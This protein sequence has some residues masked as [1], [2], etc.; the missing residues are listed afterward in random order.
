MKSNRDNLLPAIVERPIQYVAQTLPSIAYSGPGEIHGEPIVPLSHYLWILRLH[1]WKI[2]IFVAACVLSTVIIS[3]RLVRLYE[4]TAT[5]DIDR[6]TPPGIIGE[7]AA[8]SAVNDADQFLATQVKLI[9]SDSVLRPVALRYKLL[10]REDALS[11]ADRSK[12]SAREDAPII[13]KNLKV[14]R[15]PNTYL[16]LVNYRSADPRLAADVANAIT[17][18]YIMHTFDLRFRASSSLSTFMEKQ[19]EELHAKME[20]STGALVVFEKELN[21]IN[22]EEKTSILSSRLLQLNT[23]YTNAQADRVRKEAESLSVDDNSMEAALASVQGDSLRKLLEHLNEAQEKFAQVGGQY[24][25]NHPEYRKAAAQVAEV[26]RLLEKTRQNIADRVNVGHREAVSREGMLRAAVAETKA[27][28][29]KLNARSFEYQQLKREAE[30]DK[31]LYEELVRRIKEAGINASFQ[32][33]SIRLADAARPP[34]K[35]VFPDIPLNAILA[36]L[37]SSL[38]AVGAAVLHDLLDTTVRSAED[39]SRALNLAMLGTLPAVKNWSKRLSA[40]ITKGNTLGSA[41]LAADPLEDHALAGFTESVRTLRNNILLADFDRR[42]RTIL[43]TS[44]S[45]AEGKSTIAAHLAIAHA[46]QGKKTLL[47]DGDLRRPSVH[48]KFGFNPSAGLSSVLLEEVKWPQVL[49]KPEG[50]PA[51][52]ILPAGPSSHRASEM[53]GAGMTDL[54]DEI[55]QEYDLVILDAPPLLG[56]AEALQM[57]T[58]VD[59]VLVVARAGE[60]NRKAIASVVST[61]NRLRVNV[62]GLVLN[63][64]KRDTSDGYYYYGHYGKYYQ[65]KASDEDLQAVS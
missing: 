50:L 5:I 2:V 65:A 37:F 27:E 33:S 32:N 24:G 8:R 57:S 22:P 9:Q 4:A 63:E 6:Q 18:S 59:G 55:S 35:A 38:L 29:D 28:F 61:L 20:R 30:G 56:F 46:E 21:V 7:E 53:I 45:P 31:K 47:I 44:P 16:L 25:A 11:D 17:Q 12:S 49:F 42:L 62:L 48:R 43:V 1:R 36:L 52:D 41:A 26:E 40:V 54:L 39:V 64:V 15:P 13:L 23:E 34:V 60:T 58:S 19:I 51:L 10:E 14:T 3:S